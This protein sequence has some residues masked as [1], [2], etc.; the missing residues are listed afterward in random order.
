MATGASHSS[1]PSQ[2]QAG[3][4]QQLQMLTNWS[5]A[6]SM[7]MDSRAQAQPSA[8]L[9]GAAHPGGSPQEHPG[10]LHQQLQLPL[11]S[12]GLSGQQS[13]A[14]ELGYTPF[15]SNILAEQKST[16]RMLDTQGM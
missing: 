6:L 5:P 10:S 7:L 16:A 15:V 11:A 1:G 13:W 4:S 9:A 12:T 14:P 8:G 3:S 2:G